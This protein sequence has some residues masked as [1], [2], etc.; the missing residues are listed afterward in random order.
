M[1]IIIN[2]VISCEAP[3]PVVIILVKKK[4]NHNLP[5]DD[6]QGISYY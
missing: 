5:S 2:K 4:Q 6:I 1:R 3:F